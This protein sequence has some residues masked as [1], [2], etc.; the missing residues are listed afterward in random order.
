[1]SDDLFIGI[2]IYVNYEIN[3]IMISN[4]SIQGNANFRMFKK[5]FEKFIKNYRSKEIEIADK[6]GSRAY[7]V[8]DIDIALFD[9]V[10]YF[11]SYNIRIKTV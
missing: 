9:M 5:E 3:S 6:F 7:N 2:Y 1:M 11:D 10:Q 4:S 8:K